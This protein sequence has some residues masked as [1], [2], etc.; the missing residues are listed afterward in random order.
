[1]NHFQNQYN[2]LI[3]NSCEVGSFACPMKVGKSEVVP[4][5]L[6][7]PLRQ[8]MEYTMYSGSLVLPPDES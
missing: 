2:I 7:W 4:S 6:I 8:K 3:R 1:M 5:V